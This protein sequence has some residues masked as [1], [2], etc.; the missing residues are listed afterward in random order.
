MKKIILIFLINLPL[1][2]NAM[3]QPPAPALAEHVITEPKIAPNTSSST[4]E[5]SSSA[6]EDIELYT[7]QSK[8]LQCPKCSVVFKSLAGLKRHQQYERELRPIEYQTIKRQAAEA[9][10][11]SLPHP[12]QGK[13][14]YPYTRCTSNGTAIYKCNVCGHSSP[15]YQAIHYHIKSQH[16]GNLN[17]SEQQQKASVTQAPFPSDTPTQPKDQP[18][19]SLE[20]FSIR[21]L[22]NPGEQ[23]TQNQAAT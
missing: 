6:A 22:L 7:R 16:P 9:Q 10:P 8:R 15:A 2:L 12:I 13:H 19:Q 3:E 17:P 11:L 21:Y 1:L 5:D 14:H 23:P 4:E 20:D 18:T